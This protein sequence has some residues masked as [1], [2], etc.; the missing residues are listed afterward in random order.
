MAVE[1]EAML[2]GIIPAPPVIFVTKIKEL[3]IPKSIAVF[4]TPTKMLM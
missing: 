1:K 3:S 4:K 2:R